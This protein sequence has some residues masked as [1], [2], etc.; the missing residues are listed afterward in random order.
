MEG[1]QLSAPDTVSP[2][3]TAQWLPLMT[4]SPEFTSAH[5]ETAAA[6]NSFSLGF[7]GRLGLGLNL[8]L[9]SS[10]RADVVPA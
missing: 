5:R 9:A 2:Q 10:S 4:R 8:V 7:E 3:H 6:I 1:S